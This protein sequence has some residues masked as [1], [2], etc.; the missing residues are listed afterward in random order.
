MLFC[1]KCGPVDSTL[2]SL[3][4]GEPMQCHKCMDFT[5]EIVEDEKPKATLKIFKGKTTLKEYENNL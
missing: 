5:V 3:E 2:T 1:T 4:E